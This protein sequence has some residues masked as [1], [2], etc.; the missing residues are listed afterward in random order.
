MNYRK[1]NQV[2]ILIAGTVLNVASLFQK[3]N[4]SSGT[5]YAAFDLANTFS[6]TPAHKIHQKFTCIVL[7]LGY[8]N[9]PC[10]CH[11]LVL[12]DL[13]HLSL[14]Q[15]ITSVY[16]INDIILIG[17]SMQGVTTTLDLL[18]RHLCVRG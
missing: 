12:R 3:F 16:Y 4:T 1:F 7:P 14:P 5:W 8:I 17:P 10:L 9:S 2:M 11:S 15:D 18:I 6:S 13:D